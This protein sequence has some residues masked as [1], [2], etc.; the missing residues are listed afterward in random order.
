MKQ[1]G[2]N[3]EPERAGQQLYLD[4][5]YIFQ[6]AEGKKLKFLFW[7][8]ITEQPWPKAHCQW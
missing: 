5:V 8:L 3:S 2:I 1:E 7:Y 4:P 6:G